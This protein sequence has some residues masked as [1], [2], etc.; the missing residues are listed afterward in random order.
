MSESLKL[1]NKYKDLIFNINY[2]TFV[3]GAEED[4]NV[5][6]EPKMAEWHISEFEDLYLTV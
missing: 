6:A 3:P 1:L 5:K 4:L 2:T